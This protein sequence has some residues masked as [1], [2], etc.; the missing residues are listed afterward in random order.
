MCWTSNL[1][2]AKAQFPNLSFHLHPELGSPRAEACHPHNSRESETQD[3]ERNRAFNSTPSYRKP[4]PSSQKAL[5]PQPPPF[6]PQPKCSMFH[7]LS[8]PKPQTSNPDALNPKKAEGRRG[9]GPKR[10]PE[11]SAEAGAKPPNTVG[12]DDYDVISSNIYLFRG[13][14]IY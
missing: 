6:T 3:P 11:A 8:I 10:I 2:T 12:S 5:N 13:P 1:P 14:N 4:A 7:T 9:F